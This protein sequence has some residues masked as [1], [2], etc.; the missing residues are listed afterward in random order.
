MSPPRFWLTLLA[1]SMLSLGF[2]VL[3]LGLVFRALG[4]V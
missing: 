1:I 3:V 2:W 4:F